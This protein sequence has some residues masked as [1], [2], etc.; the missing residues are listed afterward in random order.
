M[1]IKKRTSKYVAELKI[2]KQQARWIS[3]YLCVGMDYNNYSRKEMDETYKNI[4]DKHSLECLSRDASFVMLAEGIF[5]CE[6]LYMLSIDLERKLDREVTSCKSKGQ[7][8]DHKVF[9]SALKSEYESKKQYLSLELFYYLH[10][11][12]TESD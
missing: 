12:G 7:L 11:L 3:H 2:T 1:P 10:N 6:E 8:W 4:T 9:F 5:R